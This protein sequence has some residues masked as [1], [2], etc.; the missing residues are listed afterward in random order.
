M[1]AQRFHRFLPAVD[2]LQHSLRQARFLQQLRNS[3]GAE[4]NELRRLEN[5][6]IPQRERVGDRP[7]RHHVREVERG[8]RGDD[9]Q[10]ISLD[11]ALDAATHFQHF[12][13]SDLR[14]RAG[15]LAELG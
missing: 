7:I 11:P 1:V 13:R 5:Q 4:R 8:N 6:T 12:S 14:Q 2:D 3:S 15:K 10:R 9:A